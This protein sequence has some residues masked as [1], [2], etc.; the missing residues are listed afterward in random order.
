MNIL[1]TLWWLMKDNFQ[2]F[3][4]ILF[5]KREKIVYVDLKSLISFGGRN[6]QL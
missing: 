2:L 6:G 3:F 1:G 5:A 4:K